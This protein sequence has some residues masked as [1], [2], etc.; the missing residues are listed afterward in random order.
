MSRGWNKAERLVEIERLYLQRAYSDIELGER[1]GVSRQT[2]FRDRIALSGKVFLVEVSSGKYKIDRKTYLSNIRVDLNEALALYLAA[3]RAS[4]QTRLAFSKTASA[5]EKLALALKQPMMEKLV[6]AAEEILSQ[7][8]DPEREKILNVIAQGWV[9]ER[10]IR[11]RYQG[12]LAKESREFVV[13]PYLIEPSPWSDGVY[14]IG[15]SD[16]HKRVATFKIERIKHASLTLEAF[17]IPDDFD[18]K[19]LLKYAWGI[20]GSEGEPE[21]VKFQFA[22]GVA[23]RRL[24]ESVWHPLEI[25]TDTLEGGCIW[26]APIAE[27]REMLPWIRGWGAD[28]EVLEP[29]KLRG[30]LI[31]T[32]KN[33]NQL[34]Q[35]MPGIG[36]LPH[37][38]PYAKTNPENREEVHLLLYHLIDVG[39][40]TLIMWQ[41][42]LTDSIRQRLAQILNLSIDNTGR[43]LAFLS[44]L[45]DLGKAGP[46]YQKKYAPAW[47]KEV[48]HKAGLKLDG[49]GRAFDKTFPHGIVTTWALKTILPEI[50]QMERRYAQKIAI[51]LGGHHGIWP[52]PRATDHLEDDKNWDALRRDLVWELQAVFSPPVEVLATASI[53]DQNTFFTILSGLVTVADW[54]GSRNNERFGFIEKPVPTRR[55]AEQSI[56]HAKAELV[57][58]GWIGWRPTGES[59]DFSETF[60][61]LNFTE[62]RPVQQA[63]IEAAKSLEPPTLLI[64]EAPTGLGKTETA[65]YLADCWLEQEKGRGL[66]IAMPTQATS[67]QM[68]DRVKEYLE[69]RYPKEFVNL[70]LVHGQA[71]WSDK[72]KEIEL[73][74]VGDSI[75]DGIAAMAW[76]K[77]RKRTL[78]APFGVGTVDQT[79]MSILQTKHFFVRLFGLAHKVVIFDEVHAY[80]TYMNTLFHHLLEWLNA[81]GTSVIVLSA[82]L[83]VETRRAMV[84][85]YTG[86]ELIDNETAY[87]ALTIA[88]M[89]S[90]KT[91][92][93]PEPKSFSIQLDWS[94]GRGPAQIVEF[95]KSNL[96]KG[97][98]A[99]VICNTVGRAQDVFRTIREARI[100][101][102]DDLILFHSRFP[103]IWRKEIEE[104]V[105][106]KFA[107]NG[108]RPKKAIVVATQVIEQSLDIDFDLMITDLAPV[109]LVLQRAGRLHRHMENERYGLPRWLVITKPEKDEVGLLDFEA[110]KWVYAPYILLRSYL[111]L[112]Q[113]SQL[114]IPGDTKEIIEAVYDDAYRFDLPDSSWQDAMQIELRR[115]QNK[116]RETRARA[117]QPLILKPTNRRLLAQP[118]S[119][120]EEDDPTTHKAFRAQTRDIDFSITIVCL[121]RINGGV[122]IYNEERK[123]IAFDLEANLDPDLVQ[124]LLKNSLGLQ[125]RRVGKYFVDQKIPKLWQ[126]NAAL[127][128]VRYVIFDDGVCHDVP[129]FTLIITPEFG[130][131]IIKQEDE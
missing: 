131:E 49:L 108:Q 48:L 41:Y 105:L 47:L 24:K 129:G 4:Q 56:L 126:D 100:V 119:D 57:E 45:H 87:P 77:P 70:H 109:D 118:I 1:L 88:N 80:D 14:L 51:S 111:I 98:C 67:N 92:T 115:L 107:K 102:D 44:A 35:I 7:R 73:Q 20:W 2:V 62:L 8:A 39:Q 58:L 53:P 46:A 106:D 64:L 69:N 96:V 63:V 122:G 86:Q 112:H 15:E 65:L 117:S 21:V 113:R 94:V 101:P 6:K 68:F 104:K 110:D 16:I 36:R 9:E 42:V 124:Y 5:L 90:Q 89:A 55:Y 19:E 103:P 128:H 127:R 10:K 79:L 60:A 99:A 121:H 32:T 93:L 23:T 3:R 27:W 31:K 18:E 75:A 130:L 84:K 30:E 17:K 12:L 52:P 66:Y 82:T 114:S 54:I 78:L 97:G 81:I 26:E 76:F 83:P 125:H 34:Y 40:V 95:L 50:L 38:I 85:A 11:F 22:S 123:M 29:L 72:M 28:C 74:G 37:Q 71:N 59:R 61:Y 43:L 33:I 120:L 25:V 91:L 13:A 116:E